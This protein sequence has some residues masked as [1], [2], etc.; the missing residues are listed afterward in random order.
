METSY[1][2]SPKILIV[3][4]EPFIAENLQEMLS[5]FGYDNTEIANSAN[6]A[7]KAI[8]AARP[9]LVLLDVK[10]KGDQDGIELGGI[11]KEQYQVPFVYI[12]SYSDKDTVNRAKHTQ[13]L[14][15]IVKPFTKDD[16][17][18]AI[19][20]ALFS[21]NRIAVK[22]GDNL[23][24][25]NPTTY[26]NDSIFIKKKSMLEKV[27]Y[28]DLFWIEADGNHITI[29][30]SDGRTFTI[31]KSLKEITDRLPKDRFLRVHK[32][33]VVLVDAVTA[34]DTNFVY[35]NEK[36]I[37]IGRSYYNAFTATLNTINAS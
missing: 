8:K 37:P 19:E 28:D 5:I 4:D 29:N 3:E 33:Y 17:Y 20:V 21:K 10:I 34:I 12:T 14:G 26:N 30:A 15:F 7:I 27:K 18:A 9:D 35:L 1:N 16:V 6:Q 31:R 25:S 24:A 22:S 32:S 36:K 23:V 13:P 11:I 2:N